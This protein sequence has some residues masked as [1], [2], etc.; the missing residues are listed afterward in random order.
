[1]LGARSA[2]PGF[3]AAFFSHVVFFYMTHGGLSQRWTTVSYFSSLLWSQ[4]HSIVVEREKI[5]RKKNVKETLIRQSKLLAC[6]VT[7]Y[8]QM[9]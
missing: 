1:M 4:Y 2:N 7:S 6:K 9:Q 5:Q 3:H 8:L